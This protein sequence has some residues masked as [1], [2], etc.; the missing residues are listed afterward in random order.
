M[1][2]TNTQ[3]YYNNSMPNIFLY[4][5]PHFGHK[6]VCRFT[7]RDGI[8]KM[9][10]WDDVEV[11]NEDMIVLYNDKVKPEDTCYFLGDVIWNQKYLPIL[12]QLNGTKILIRG[13]HDM[14]DIKEYLN[15][16]AEVKSYD[17]IDG[18]LLSHI[19]VHPESIGRCGTNVH[20]HLHS[21]R[22][23]KPCGFDSATGQVIYGDEID[24]RYHNVSVEMT[25][26]A[27]ILLEDLI[28][29]IQ[30]EGGITTIRQNY[31][32]T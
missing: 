29:K 10:P 4:S 7:Q 11:M 1:L 12:S 15:Y 19:P 31:S 9:R 22:V 21:N 2:D 23:M 28:K 25:E 6:N 26:F 24:V 8:T 18:L 30:T 27:P 16:F 5:D 32:Y 13:N 14:L 20:G 3:R 17:F